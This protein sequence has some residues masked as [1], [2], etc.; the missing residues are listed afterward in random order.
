MSIKLRSVIVNEEEIADFNNY[1]CYPAQ[2]TARLDLIKAL[3]SDG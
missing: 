1:W 2:N 3:R